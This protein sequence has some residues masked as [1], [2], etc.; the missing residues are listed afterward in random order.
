MPGGRGATGRFGPA[1]S[2]FCAGAIV[3]AAFPAL[4]SAAGIAGLALAGVLAFLWPP[5]RV[6]AALPAGMLWF[7]LHALWFQHQAWP[8]ARAGEVVEF[9]G[10]VVGLPDQR[11]GRAVLEVRPVGAAHEKEL[12]GRVLLRWYRPREWFRP[13]ETWRLR[14]RLEPPHGR[15]N[16][17]LFDYQRYLIARGIGATGRI[18]SAERIV[19]GGWRGAPDRFRQRFADWLQAE[20]VNLDAA[21]LHRALTVG[22]RS[23]MSDELSGRLRR[24]GTAHLLSISGLHVGMVAGLAG[25][26]GGVFAVLFGGLPGWPDRRRLMLVTGL[27]GAL[28]YAL[29]AGFSLPT[30]RALVMLAAGFGAVLWRRPIQP[31]RALLMALLAVLLIDPMAPLATGFWLSFAA[32]AVLIWAFA[33]RGADRG[34]H[35]TGRSS[36]VGAAAWTGGWVGGLMRAQVVIAVGMLPLNIGVFGQWAPVALAANLVAIPLVGLWVL[37]ALLVAMGL[38]ALGLPAGG[39]LAF[40]EHGLGAL[41]SVLEWLTVF[42]AGLPPWAA[43]AGPSP[44]LL[45]MLLA[46]LG[47]VWLIAPRGWPLRPAG[48]LLLLPLLWP[49]ERGLGPG[50][51][52]LLLADVGHGQAAIVRTASSVLLYGTGPGDGDAAS[53]VPG[54]IEPLV[55]QGGFRSV[56]RIVVPYRHGGYAGGL[57]EARRQWPEARIDSPTGRYGD[58]CRAGQRWRV[59]GVG[60]RYLHPSPALPDLGGDSSCVLEVRSAAG[61]LL[62]T[63]GIGRA[64]GRRLLIEGRARDIDVVVLPRFGR[65]EALDERWLKRLDPDFALV[66][67][68]TFDG[69][70]QPSPDTRGLLAALAVPLLDTGR[71]GALRAR[72]VHDAPVAVRAAIEEV[73]RFWRDSRRCGPAA[74]R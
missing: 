29:L 19:A 65:R 68:G 47:G 10:R 4:P 48:A 49:A 50:E 35:V 41:L 33:G 39:A 61:S 45:A 32:V 52:E 5:A 31:G 36:V 71:C 63:G 16:P 13:G 69:R 62:L 21:A 20:T 7:L 56:D 18:V 42:D 55:R 11:G 1:A 64:V 59:D 43:P 26:A 12:P 72:F 46:G 27:A 58:R 8:A 14:A 60:F 30:Q 23:A 25:L 6:W 17:G 2:L 40:S 74:S 53:L 67:T 51:F 15:V 28:A 70:A 57:A 54:T 66:S 34:R 37:P 38:F 9:A 44:G 22:D 24:T 73:Q 3:A